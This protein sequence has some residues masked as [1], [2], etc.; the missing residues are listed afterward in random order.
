[1]RFPFVSR[2][3]FD[4]VYADRERIRGERDKAV[5]ERDTAVFNRR[6]ITEQYT[7]TAIVNTCLTD[8]LTAL[9]DR[10][11]AEKRRADRLQQRLD[12][13]VGLPAGGVLSSQTWQPGYTAPKKE[14]P[15]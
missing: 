12:D 14:T 3:S 9:R 1:M 11:A 15:S 4:Y 6:Q 5:E 10:L 7:D 8:D 2:A 13:A